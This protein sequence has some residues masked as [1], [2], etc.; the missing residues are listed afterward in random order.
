MKEKPVIKGQ[1][2]CLTPVRYNPGNIGQ[3]PTKVRTG[4]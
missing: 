3:G 1:F 4:E 2:H